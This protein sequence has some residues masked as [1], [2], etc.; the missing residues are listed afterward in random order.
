MNDCGS[1]KDRMIMDSAWNLFY[2]YF[3]NGRADLM[4]AYLE[5]PGS[6]NGVKA[7]LKSIQILL[8]GDSRA[9]GYGYAIA[10]LFKRQRDL[11]EPILDG[12]NL[13][14]YRDYLWNSDVRLHL[15]DAFVSKNIYTKIKYGKL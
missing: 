8:E 10:S 14:D 7:E 4:H 5:M 9:P 2:F 15:P 3:E 12:L 13:E 6:I 11:K 1:I